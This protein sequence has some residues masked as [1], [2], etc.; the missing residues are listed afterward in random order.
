MHF[1][2]LPAEGSLLQQVGQQIFHTHCHLALQTLVADTGTVLAQRASK[3]PDPHPQGP[4]WS[5]TVTKYL[6]IGTNS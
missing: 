2:F 1:Q 4:S 6:D 3:T 5:R